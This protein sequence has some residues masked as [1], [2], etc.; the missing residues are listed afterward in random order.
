MHINGNQMKLSTTNPYSVAAEK[1]VAAQRITAAR[2][3]TR[4]SVTG[5]KQKSIPDE[6]SIVGNWTVAQHSQSQ[7]D[8]EFHAALSGQV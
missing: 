7:P 2:K 3:R 8:V 6:S 4:K 5:A 1:A